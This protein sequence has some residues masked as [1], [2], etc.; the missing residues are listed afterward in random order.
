MFVLVGCSM[1]FFS[2]RRRHTSCALVT[3]VQTCALPISGAFDMIGERAGQQ[4]GAER[5]RAQLGMREPKIIAAFGDVI[6]KFVGERE[7]EPYRRA[8]ASDQID[9]RDLGLLARVEREIG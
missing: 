4:F 1:F 2:S 8:V 5:G 9:A 6:G 7:A 3:G